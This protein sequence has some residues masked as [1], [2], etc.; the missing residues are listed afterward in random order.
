MSA[1]GRWS[2]ARLALVLY[3]L[4]AGAMAVNLFFLSL[5]GQALGAPAL[6]PVTATLGGAALG[7]PAAWLAGRWFRRLMDRADASG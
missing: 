3:P 2:V 6:E 1:P 7:V 5:M 4:T